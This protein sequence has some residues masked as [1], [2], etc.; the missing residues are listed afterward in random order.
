MSQTE[1]AALIGAIA[2]ILYFLADILKVYAYRDTIKAFAE[3][4]T[5]QLDAFLAQYGTQLKPVNEVLLALNTLVDQDSDALAQ[6]LP[7]EALHTLRDIL[8]QAITLT[9]GSAPEDKPQG[10]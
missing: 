9:D 6:A 5:P 1:I 2:I 3:Q 8:N 7:T 10:G 4:Y